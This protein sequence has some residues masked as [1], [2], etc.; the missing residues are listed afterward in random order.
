MDRIE[1]INSIA[2]NFECESY[3]EIGLRNPEECF[4]LIECENKDSVDPGFETDFNLA[5][6]EGGVYVIEDVYTSY[7]DGPEEFGGGMKNP[8]SSVEFFKNLV[9]EVNF[10]GELHETPDL[11]VYARREEDLVKKVK[12]REMNIRTDIESINFMN[13]I[14][15]VTKK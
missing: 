4:N 10:N 15:I 9:D 1:I 3:L 11:F 7:W 13:S 12:D 6:K 8:N 14:I 2:R 5:L